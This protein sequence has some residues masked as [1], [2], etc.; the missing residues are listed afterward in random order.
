MKNF[1]DFKNFVHEGIN[2]C[3]IRCDLNLPSETEDLSRVYSIKETVHRVLDLGIKVILISHYKRPSKSEAFMQKFSLSAIS[4]KVWEILEVNVNFMGTNI[5][6][7]SQNSIL[8]EVTLLENLRFYEEEEQ[9]NDVF[10]QKLAKLA[11]VY[12]NE[13]FSVAHRAHASVSAI[14]KFLPSFAGI[15]FENEVKQISKIRENIERPYT[16]IIGGSKVSSKIDV[17]REIS[18]KADYLVITGAMAN[19]FLTALGHKLG[20]SII[21][22]T[23]IKIAQ[24]I[25]KASKAEIILPTDFLVS[26]DINM[27]GVCFDINDE[28]PEN[29]SCF[30]IGTNTIEKIKSTIKISKTLLWNGALGAFEF[31]NFDTSS[32]EISKYVA[33]RTKNNELTSVIGGG[34]TIASIKEYKNEMTFVSTAGGAFLEY[35]S[36]YNLPGILALQSFNIS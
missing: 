9:N 10:A 25:I 29:S 6:E 36:G 31:A 32:K 21:E 22:K 13:A 24:E 19:T 18:Q 17:L 33:K 34:E 8:G 14:T 20:A 5:F 15:A 11:D 1:D 16:A 30:D 35:V 23:Y 2:R 28:V 7:L 4:E 12:I 3:I 27:P 26:S